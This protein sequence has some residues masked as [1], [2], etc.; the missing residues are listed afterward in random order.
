MYDKEG[1]MSREDGTR[2]VKGLNIKCA[3]LRAGGKGRDLM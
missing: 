1:L 2:P 3:G